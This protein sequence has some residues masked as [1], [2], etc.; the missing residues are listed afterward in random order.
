MF[1]ECESFCQ[2]KFSV[3]LSKVKNSKK[4]ME[5]FLN[6]VKYFFLHFLAFE[7]N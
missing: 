7:E 2:F 1:G 3:Q 6:N 4:D 5:S